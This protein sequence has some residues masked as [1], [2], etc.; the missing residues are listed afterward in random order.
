M[1]NRTLM[2]T[3]NWTVLLEYIIGY[4]HIHTHYI[5]ICVQVYINTI[6]MYVPTIYV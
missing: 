5:C 4:T 2:Q 1:K 6:C 3:I